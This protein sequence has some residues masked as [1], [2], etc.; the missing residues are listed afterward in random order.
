[1]AYIGQIIMVKPLQVAKAHLV[2]WFA[3]FKEK[4]QSYISCN[5]LFEGSPEHL[6]GVMGNPNRML[7]P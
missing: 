7:A 1:M 5:K 3:Q 6:A 2:P 4:Q